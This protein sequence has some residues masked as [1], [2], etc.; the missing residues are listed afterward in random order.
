[1]RWPVDALW[2]IRLDAR[3]KGEPISREAMALHLE[4][5]LNEAEVRGVHAQGLADRAANVRCL[6]KRCELDHER[7]VRH[8]RMRGDYSRQR[9]HELRTA[10][11]DDFEIRHRI[12]VEIAN[13]AAL[14]G[15]THQEAGR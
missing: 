7:I 3:H 10:G 8:E 12:D 13:G 5:G 2:Q 11:M 14:R 4:D 1:M 15:T 9:A 6:C